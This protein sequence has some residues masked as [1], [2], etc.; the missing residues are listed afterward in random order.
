MQKQIGV[1]AYFS[2]KQL[3]LLAFARQKR[4][5]H[6][7]RW[8]FRVEQNAVDHEVADRSI[9]SRGLYYQVGDLSGCLNRSV[10]QEVA[11]L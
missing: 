2:S 9:V 10:A 8:T 3:L 4:K 7:Q 1:T 11:Q 5:A 6:T